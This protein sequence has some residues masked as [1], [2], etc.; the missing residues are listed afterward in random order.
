MQHVDAYK[1]FWLL[2]FSHWMKLVSKENKHSSFLIQNCSLLYWKVRY[3][4]QQ[5]IILDFLLRYIH[6]SSLLWTLFTKL[7]CQKNKLY[8]T[9]CISHFV[10]RLREPKT[11]WKANNWKFN[12][13]RCYWEREVAIE[14]VQVREKLLLREK[15]RGCYWERARERERSCY[16]ERTREREREVAIER[17]QER[18]REKLLLREKKRGCYWER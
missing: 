3:N 16:W 8:N 10:H 13:W 14:R 2:I 1:R 18:E 6:S 11:Q 15:K 9:S 5:P 4:Q 17:E 12:H 7:H